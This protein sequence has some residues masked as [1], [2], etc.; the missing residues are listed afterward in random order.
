MTVDFMFQICDYVLAKNLGQ[1]NLNPQDFNNLA[2][3]SQYSF[4]DYLLGEFQSYQGGRPVAKVQFGM[5]ES[6]RQRLTPFIKPVVTLTADVSG[7]AAYP[8]DYQQMDAM[9]DST[10]NRIRFV[11]QHKLYSFIFS[12]IDPIN[13]NPIYLIE[14]NGFR[15]YPNTNFNGTASP[16]AL[17][18][19][20]STPPNIVWNSTTDSNGRLVYNPI[21]S[22]DP[23]WYDVDC[24][25][26]IARILRM[27]GVNL[28]NQDVEKFAQEIKIQGQ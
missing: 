17:L 2:N 20:V 7:F 4:L 6:V 24:A 8:V 27:C 9:Y 21:G 15:F 25:E 1:G 23:E 13:T 26:I 10:M 3:I 14:N 12:V 5:N 28:Q 22:V 11:P 18:S 16:A 19:Y